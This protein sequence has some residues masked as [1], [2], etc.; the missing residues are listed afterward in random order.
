MRIKRRGAIFLLIAY[1]CGALCS[2]GK[3]DAVNNDKVQ[4]EEELS[5]ITVVYEGEYNKENGVIIIYEKDDPDNNGKTD[6]IAI[7]T[8][9]ADDPY[10]ELPAGNYIIANYN[11][12][13]E[14]ELDGKTDYV[15]TVNLQ[16]GTITRTN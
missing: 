4:T 1:I 2:C 5:R 6:I 10:V 14:I 15:F 13:Y 11:C 9:N 7:I 3:N 8:P 16:D 12:N